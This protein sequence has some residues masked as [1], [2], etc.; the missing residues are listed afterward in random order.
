CMGK[1]YRHTGDLAFINTNWTKITQVANALMADNEPNFDKYRNGLVYDG[2]EGGFY[3]NETAV[4]ARVM[5]GF[6]SAYDLSVTRGSPVTAWRDKANALEFEFYRQF[7]DN[8]NW[9]W[10]PNQLPS[11]A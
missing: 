6:R 5:L 4:T 9:Q 7:V 2:G 3:D 11:N 8:Q 1:Y 10:T